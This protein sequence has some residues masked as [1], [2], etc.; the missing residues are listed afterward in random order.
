[1]KLSE[2]KLR[3]RFNA[4][5]QAISNTIKVALLYERV[6]AALLEARRHIDGG[7]SQLHGML[8]QSVAQEIWLRYARS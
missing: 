8:E 2:W 3:V 1:M 4:Q 5:D 6:D 7:L